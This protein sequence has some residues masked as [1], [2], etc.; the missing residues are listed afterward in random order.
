M[1]PL[2]FWREGQTLNKRLGTKLINEA[3][4]SRGNGGGTY[5]DM[6]AG[7]HLLEE[8]TFSQTCRGL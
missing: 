3:M 8:V 4:Q 6:N 1:L 7:K 5:L 2:A